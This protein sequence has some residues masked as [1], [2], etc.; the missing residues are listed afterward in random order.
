LQHDNARPHV[1]EPVTQKI[2]ELGWQV[3]PH[4]P[5]S[6]DLAPSDYH[7]FR[8]LTNNLRE[9]SFRDEDELRRCIQEFFYSKPPEFYKRGIYDLP[10]RWREVVDSHGKYIVEK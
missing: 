5:Y 8:A 4:P 7:L 3:S 6:P 1:S 10:R 2:R 9:R